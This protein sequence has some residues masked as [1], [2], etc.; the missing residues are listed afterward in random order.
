MARFEPLLVDHLLR[1]S[2][3][4]T[5]VR[6]ALT[7]ERSGELGGAPKVLL[8]DFDPRGLEIFRTNLDLIRDCCALI[9]AECFVAKQATLIHEGLDDVDRARCRFDFHGFDEQAHLRAY[10][11]LYDVIDAEIRPERVIDCTPLSGEPGLWEDHVHPTPG[12]AT[13]IAHVVADSLE[14]WLRARDG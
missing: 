5:K 4:L 7:S 12:G 10:R 6:L 11:G 13:A 8:S 3:F 9:G 1:W 2:Q 14:A